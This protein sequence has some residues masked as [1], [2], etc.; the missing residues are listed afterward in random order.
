MNKTFT[1]WIAAATLAAATVTSTAVADGHKRPAATIVDTAIAVNQTSGEFSILIA[2][3]QRAGLVG[4]LDGKGQYTVF[5][6]TDQ[7]FI[8]AGFPLEVVQGADPAALSG[9]LL[10][11]VTPGRRDSKTVL[12]QQRLNT[13]SG[14]FIGQFGAQL[15][16]STDER[17]NFVAI[18]V[19]TSNGIVHIIDKVLI[20]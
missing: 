2:A 5:A 9:I 10:Y 12:S 1:R 3:L 16:D 4:A 13:L 20:P 11:H 17:A 19:G 18:D 8:D 15:I 14:G 7:A 6:P